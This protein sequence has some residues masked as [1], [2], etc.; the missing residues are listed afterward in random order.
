LDGHRRRDLV[1]LGGTA[2]LGGSVAGCAQESE[3]TPAPDPTETTAPTATEEET[4]DEPPT[5]TLQGGP[6]TTDGLGAL[7]LADNVESNAYSHHPQAEY[8]P[9]AETTFHVYQSTDT[10]G[11]GES[12]ASTD[13]D[14]YAVAFD[15]AEQAVEGPVRVGFNPIR[16][17]DNHGVPGMT[18]DGDGY[19]HAFFGCHNSAIQYARSAEPY[20]ISTWVHPPS[21]EEGAA[22]LPAPTGTYTSAAYHPGEDAVYVFYRSNGG[23]EAYPSHVHATLAR[24]D[25]NGESWTDVNEGIIDQSDAPGNHFDAYV[26]DLDVWAGRVHVTWTIAEGDVHDQSRRNVYHAAYDPE[27]GQMQTTS[28]ENLGETIT[29]PQPIA[30]CLVKDTGDASISGEYNAGGDSIRGF[31]HGYDPASD[32]AYIPA[33]YGVDDETSVVRLYSYEGVSDGSGEWQESPVILEQSPPSPHCYLRVDDAG[34]P[35]IDKPSAAGEQGF[36]VPTEDGF[37]HRPVDLPSGVGAAKPVANGPDEFGW[38]GTRWVSGRDETSGR[39]IHTYGVGE[40]LAGSATHPRPPGNLRVTDRSGTSVTVDW[41]EGLAGPASLERYDVYVDGERRERL[42]EV[43]NDDASY[44]QTYATLDLEA[45][46][47]AIWVTLTTREGTE[48]RRS[49]VVSVEP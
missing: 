1:R 23:G 46:E 45:G 5:G 18:V 38:I 16:A 21:G 27:S 7:F 19:V 34:T 26:K 8:A 9:D 13:G 17:G 47:H 31:N 24:G 40:G 28:G 36:W 22:P 25:D 32:T 3:T 2:L 6:E 43:P 42:S 39:H 4:T 37:E 15:H 49:N 14:A 30:D 10:G 48:S 12:D 44:P 33:S 11:T 41:D 20:D 29:W 35:Q